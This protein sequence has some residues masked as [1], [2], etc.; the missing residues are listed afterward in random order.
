MRRWSWRSEND[1]VFLLIL[2]RYRSPVFLEEFFGVD[3]YD[4][5][6]V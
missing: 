4:L 2:M 6:V 5:F 3:A 1:S